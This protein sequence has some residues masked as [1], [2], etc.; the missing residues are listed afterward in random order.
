MS[1][2]P[3][4]W[5]GIDALCDSGENRLQNGALFWFP[6]PLIISSRL[7]ARWYAMGDRTNLFPMPNPKLTSGPVD[8]NYPNV[9][10]YKQL[11]EEAKA[12]SLQAPC[13]HRDAEA[14]EGRDRLGL[15]IVSV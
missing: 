3:S 4:S 1:L 10:D 11:I 13:E 6:P 2:S 5:N 8:A 15:E 9:V 7:K 12:S 14:T